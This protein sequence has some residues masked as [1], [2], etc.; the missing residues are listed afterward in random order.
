MRGRKKAFLQAGEMLRRIEADK[1][2]VST[3]RTLNLRLL[4]EIL[5]DEGHILRLRDQCKNLNRQL[6]T[7]RLPKAEAN[8]V[9]G[10]I[11]ALERRVKRYQDQIYFWRCFGDGLAYAYISSF[12][13]KHV[14]FDTTAGLPKQESG[15]ISGK[16]GLEREVAMLDAAI[17]HG[18]PA[19]LS[20][21]TNIVRYGDVCLLG[22]EDPVPI[23]VKSRTGLNQRGQRQ[24]AKLDTLTGFLETDQAQDFRGVPQMRR[25]AYDQPYQDHVE[26]LN[27]CVERAHRNGHDI[28]SPEP[29]LVYAAYYDDTPFQ[30]FLDG[31]AMSQPTVF[32]LNLEK[33]ERNWAPYLPFI[34]SI[35]DL[36]RLHDFVVGEL[37]VYVALDLQVL[38][39][40][41]S[42]PG[43]HA[44]VV[45][46]FDLALVFENPT[47]GAQ[48]ALSRQFIGRI[49]FEFA[50]LA[51]IAGQGRAFVGRTASEVADGV[52]VNVAF[53]QALMDRFNAMPRIVEAS[54]PATLEAARATGPESG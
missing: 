12:N 16:A 29:G 33:S 41:I 48:F 34:N 11:A 39:D 44:A 19:V 14:F 35:R 37:V 22:G 42:L 28:A 6:K 2:D 49:G 26:A 21:L 45:E 47:T 43:W 13:L 40:Q 50:S 23:E 5:R 7:G 52:E 10:K 25:R 24:A 30:A 31:L 54:S 17:A 38:C 53:T 32:L 4:K 18:V 46:D 36:E 20:D 3:V 1:D 8:F 51:W 9:R 15:F 27:A